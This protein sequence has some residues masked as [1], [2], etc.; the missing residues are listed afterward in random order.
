MSETN[1]PASSPDFHAAEES[2]ATGASTCPPA[3]SQPESSKPAPGPLDGPQTHGFFKRL[4]IRQHLRKA[5]TAVG[6]GVEDG[7]VPYV[8]VHR[9]KHASLPPD[10]RV[11]K[12]PGLI[13]CHSVA[14]VTGKQ[15]FS[16]WR[17]KKAFD[18]NGDRF[19]AEYTD[20]PLGNSFAGPVSSF[21][22][23]K[24]SL[25]RRFPVWTILITLSTA[26]AAV[27]AL[28]ERG[29][30]LL[31]APEA[32][33]E[34]ALVTPHLLNTRT[35]PVGFQATNRCR[36][37]PIQLDIRAA[38]VPAGTKNAMIPDET[39]ARLSRIEPGVTKSFSL[40]DPMPTLAGV[41]GG[42]AAYEYHLRIEAKAGIWKT[43]TFNVTSGPVSVWK[44]VDVS[45]PV[46]DRVFPGGCLI[47]GYVYS[48]KVQTAVF[49]PTV[50][51]RAPMG[52]AL[53]KV[54]PS[55]PAS[56]TLSPKRSTAR[57]TIDVPGLTAFQRY[58]Y[59]IVVKG[60]SFN[61]DECEFVTK[62]LE[63][64]VHEKWGMK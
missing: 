16:Y 55:E 48:G 4:R 13:F 26:V 49:S 60:D 23:R 41:S 29:A 10:L 28:W 62:N 7:D 40:P 32:Y 45:A 44:A 22:H 63:V 2:V 34:L 9:A 50:S 38:L 35:E 27:F 20:D 58:L 57:D 1:P 19:V 12:H 59:Q 52:S 47:K 5:M 64:S 42:P 31:E 17:S 30:Q 53:V 21:R 6:I 15:L 11:K 14:T 36:F 61:K 43:K 54:G 18:A 8:V 37:A 39:K 46:L 33:V 25:L 51:S 56:L 3:S 24:D